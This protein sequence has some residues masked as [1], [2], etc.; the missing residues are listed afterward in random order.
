MI[1][2]TVENR[3]VLSVPDQTQV[4]FMS[5]LSLGNPFVPWRGGVRESVSN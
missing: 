5:L 4:V 3:K 2:G 1:Q